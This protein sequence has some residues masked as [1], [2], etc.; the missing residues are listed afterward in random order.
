M[1]DSEDI[2]DGYFPLRISVADM[3][4]RSG[5]RHAA[6]ELSFA[7]IIEVPGLAPDAPVPL[8][9]Q[10]GRAGL[11][12]HAALVVTIGPTEAQIG[13]RARWRWLDGLPGAATLDPMIRLAEPALVSV[14]PLEQAVDVP[15][16]I[17]PEPGR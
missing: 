16:S 14:Q 12:L 7:P 6:L 4:A 11:I 17:L 3:M 9:I 15:P 10:S 2:L 5:L 8:S 13:G 1:R